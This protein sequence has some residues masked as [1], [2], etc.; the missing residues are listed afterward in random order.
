LELAPSNRLSARLTGL[1]VRH[2][3]HRAI[4][5]ECPQNVFK[6]DFFYPQGFGRPKIDEAVAAAVT[7]EFKER[8]P[9]GRDE[10]FCDREYCG[11]ASCGLWPVEKT[12][13]VHT[14]SPGFISIL[15]TEESYTGG[16]HGNLDFNVMNF[17]LENDRP[18][19]LADLFPQPEKSVPAY[20]GQVYSEWCRTRGVNFPLHFKTD[21]EGKCRPGEV[22]KP[23]DEFQ[24]AGNLED[25]GR[26][27]FT[28][29]G[30][31]LLLGPYESGSYASGS[32]ALDLPKEMLLEIGANPALWEIRASGD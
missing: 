8:L 17:N 29:Q 7:A 14:P 1:T 16:A 24:E 15:F 23:P 12:F 13:A 6:L 11:S 27:I 32:Q 22:L 10:F 3:G 2:L 4:G 5:P 18:M 30:V 25:L 21:T 9:E 26:L 19:T 28:A 31:T 20:W